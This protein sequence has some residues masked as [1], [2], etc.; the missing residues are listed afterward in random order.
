MFTT[1]IHCLAPLPCSASQQIG[2]LNDVCEFRNGTFYILLLIVTVGCSSN[3]AEGF[4]ESKPNRNKTITLGF[5][6]SGKDNVYYVPIEQGVFDA[7]RNS[8]IESS[9]AC[10]T[11]EPLLIEEAHVAVVSVHSLSDIETVQPLS[12]EICDSSKRQL[13]RIEFIYFSKS[14]GSVE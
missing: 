4:Q 6:D 12:V 14:K 3:V 8:S 7:I 2:V 10:V 9:C 13:L 5:V 11:V 1:S